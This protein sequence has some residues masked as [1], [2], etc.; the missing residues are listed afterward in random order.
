MAAGYAIIPNL[1][2]ASAVEGLKEL[3]EV[4]FQLDIPQIMS[5]MSALVFSILLGL[6]AVWTRAEIMTKLLD[7]FQRIVL[8]IVSKV[9]I[10][11][12]P[13][14]IAAT[15]CGLAYE[16]TITRQL[17]VFIAVVLIL[18]DYRE[19]REKMKAYPLYRHVM[20]VVGRLW[21]LGG[22]WIRG[23]NT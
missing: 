7:E 1:S 13:L 3:P 8:A 12:L 9:V 21:T 18:K 14:F 17:P 4:V 6:A 23:G 19:I 22:A 11:L 20:N 16:G 5:V 15:F 10:P 2:I